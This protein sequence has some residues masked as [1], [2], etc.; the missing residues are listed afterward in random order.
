MRVVLDLDKL[1]AQGRITPAQYE[2]IKALAE[3]KAGNLAINILLGFGVWAIALGAL[4]LLNSAIASIQIGLILTSLGIYLKI[5]YPRPWGAFAQMLLLVGTL[6]SA[7]G[8]IVFTKGSV[9]GFLLITALL[10]VG[11]VLA[12]SGLLSALSALSLSATIGAMTAYDHASY[13]LIIQQP[14]LTIALFAILGWLSYQLSKRVSENYKG[15]GIIF[16]RTCLF[17]VNFGFWIGSLWG[18]SLGQPRDVWGFGKDA[19]ISDETFVIAW[20]LA[21]L[22]GVIWGIRQHRMWVVNTLTVFGAIHFYTQYFERLGAHP[23]T[24]M[25]GG[26]IALII[27]LG[28]FRYNRG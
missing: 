1:L 16:A 13:Y 26:I 4:A 19:I 11:T 17:L 15:L 24:L 5:R 21:L 6:M 7:G 2:E 8:I 3:A 28:L 12:K 25:L 23:L 9:G 20:A 22:G 18:D 27:V 10:L 14:S